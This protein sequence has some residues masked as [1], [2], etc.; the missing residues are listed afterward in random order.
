MV[1]SPPNITMVSKPI[2]LSRALQKTSCHFENSLFEFETVSGDFRGTSQPE[3]SRRAHRAR[4]RVAEKRKLARLMWGQKKAAVKWELQFLDRTASFA[5]PGHPGDKVSV[6]ITR[7]GDSWPNSLDRSSNLQRGPGRNI[8]DRR[9]IVT[10]APLTLT[11]PC[12]T[13]RPASLTDPARPD[14][15]QQFV[16]SEPVVR[17]RRLRP[18]LHLPAPHPS[19][20][21]SPNPPPP[22][23]PPPPN[24]SPP[25]SSAPALSSPAI[26]CT[27][28]FIFSIS[29]TCTSVS[30]S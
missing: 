25:R 17:G 23:P 16:N 15:S 24:G 8:Q 6:T 5:L 20:T 4:M 21:A 10:T 12:F 14:A 1:P 13:N 3:N 28:R 27:S 19:E 22:S 30:S 11:A 9:G 7:A 26:G 29:A 18:P 2:F